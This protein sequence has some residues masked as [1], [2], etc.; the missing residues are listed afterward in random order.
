VQPQRPG[1]AE[2]HLWLLWTASRKTH[3]IR[4]AVGYE[5]ALVVYGLSDLQ[6]DRV[7]LVVP[8]GFRVSQVPPEVRLHVGDRSPE[9]IG[10]RDGL[11]VV[12]PVPTLVDL[13]DEGR[14]SE[15]HI[16]AAL[17]DGLRTGIITHEDLA[18]VPKGPAHKTLHG[19][20]KEVGR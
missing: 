8:N 1:L 2:L 11:R 5:T 15:E 13:L 12:K 17:R 20:L 10:K 19:W 6:L 18:T 16:E 14:V 4:G 9:A 7:H 3:E